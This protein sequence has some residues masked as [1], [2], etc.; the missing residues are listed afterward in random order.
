MVKKVYIVE[1]KSDPF[2]KKINAVGKKIL[3]AHKKMERI[4]KR[5]QLKI[6]E[7]EKI[8]NKLKYRR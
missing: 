8:I 1:L 2:I 4:I 3:R 5:L 7:C 6:L